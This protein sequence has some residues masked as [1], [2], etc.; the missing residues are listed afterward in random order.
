VPNLWNNYPL[1]QWLIA[2]AATRAAA[3][4]Q[5]DGP[6]GTGGQPANGAWRYV[7]YYG[8]EE[9]YARTLTPAL[10]AYYEQHG[11]CWV[12]SGSTQ[13]AR[14]LADP[15]AVPT[16]VAYYRALARLADVAYR[17]SPYASGSAPVRFSYDWSFD[18]YPLAYRLPGPEVT[19]Y[20]LRS[21]ACSSAGRPLSQVR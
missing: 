11:Y 20:H 13:S 1:S 5:S 14:A 15:S 6:A 16:A 8:R 18:Y 9:Q 10:I 2:P 7:H 3:A 21:G 17:V 19:V 12:L 4:A